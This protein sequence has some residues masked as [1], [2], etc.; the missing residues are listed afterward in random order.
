VSEWMEKEKKRIKERNAKLS[1][2][3]DEPINQKSRFISVRMMYIWIKF[4]E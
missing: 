2:H 3:Q 1:G 4:K